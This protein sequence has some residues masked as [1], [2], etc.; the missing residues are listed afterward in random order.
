MSKKIGRNESCPCGSGKKYKKCCIPPSYTPPP[1]QPEPKYKF[2]RREAGLLITHLLGMAD[3]PLRRPQ[4]SFEDS[5][6]RRELL[7][8]QQ[9]KKG[10]R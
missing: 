3:M 8:L 4:E 9:A 1:P 6:L 5:G 10:D 2:S 7:A